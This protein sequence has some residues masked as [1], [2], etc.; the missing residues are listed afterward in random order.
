MN[1]AAFVILG[2]ALL[3]LLLM[4]ISVRQTERY[5]TEEQHIRRSARRTQHDLDQLFGK[6]AEEMMNQA[7]RHQGRPPWQ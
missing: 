3:L 2:L 7:R 1:I 6:A 4:L 5:P